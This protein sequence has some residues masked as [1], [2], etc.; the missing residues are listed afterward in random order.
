MVEF[1]TNPYYAFTLI[2]VTVLV[3]LGIYKYLKTPSSKFFLWNELFL[4]IIAIIGTLAII[5]KNQDSKKKFE[6]EKKENWIN[7]DFRFLKGH[8]NTNYYCLPYT[9]SKYLSDEEWNNR[10]EIRQKT[11]DW[12]REVKKILEK[13]DIY[14]FKAIPKIPSVTDNM[15]NQYNDID[16]I[17]IELEKINELIDERNKIEKEIS[18]I[19]ILGN[20]DETL[21]I[22]FILVGLGIKLSKLIYKLNKN[23]A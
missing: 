2:I 17:E 18:G 9:K 12:I 3:S 16:E 8:L 19:N 6:L 13:V 10:N 14:E 4:L 20:I 5:S 15:L 11:C 1:I 23:N 22:L 7:A 21:G